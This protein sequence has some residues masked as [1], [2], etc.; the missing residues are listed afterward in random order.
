MN[1]CAT[2]GCA[3]TSVGKSKYCAPHKEAAHVAWKARVKVDADERRD[4]NKAWAALH[5]EAHEAGIVASEAHTPV[6][7]GIKGYAPIAGGVCGFA[8]VKIAPA[9]GSFARWAKKN[10]DRAH[11]GY[12]TGLQIWCPLPTQSMTTKEAY[13]EAYAKVLQARGVKAYMGSRMD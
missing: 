1:V 4:R 7:M 9:T 2:E 5:K 12:P 6:P 11:K 3:D 10:L 13:C 8:W